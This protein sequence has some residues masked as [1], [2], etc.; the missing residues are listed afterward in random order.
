MFPTLA[1][2]MLAAPP[3]AESGEPYALLGNRLAFVTWYYVRPGGFGWYNASGQNVA[4]GGS[5]GPTGATY[6]RA[7]MPIGVR[8][9]AEKPE[10]IGPLFTDLKPW[11]TTGVHLTTVVREGDHF[12]AWGA[13]AGQ[14]PGGFCAFESTDGLHWTR[15][16]L[17]LMPVDG[18]PSN[19]IPFAEGTVFV[20]PSAP[21]EARY[22]WVQLDGMSRAD[23]DAWR[24]KHPDRWEPRAW[25]EDV[26]TAY[27]IIGATSPD[28][29]HWARLPE[30][31]VVEHSDTQIVATY[32]RRLRKYVIYTRAWWVGDR[33]EGVAPGAAWHSVGRR[34]IGRTESDT[35]DA[36]PVSQTI[37]TPPNDFPPTDLLYTNCHTELPGAPDCQLLFPAIWHLLDDT[38]SITLAGSQ[39]G[40]VW[41]YLPG[42][43]LFDTPPFGE[44]DGGCVFTHPNL[45]ELPDGS[46]VL[47]YT[48]YLFPHKYPRGQLKYNAGLLRWPK[49][50]LTAIVAD[51]QGEFAT[52][53]FVPPGASL[54]INA[55]TARG[56]RIL[57]EAAGLNGAPLPGRSFAEA[58]AI[59]GDQYRS[60][61]TWH[62]QSALPTD[63]GIML[64]I[65][66]DRARLYWLE[67][68]R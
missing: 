48:G 42:T 19:L 3:H 18:Q 2:L 10:R 66:L 22:K 21:P 29:L 52:V 41:S 46:F 6:R 8:L 14:H 56:G 54:R 34:S 40:V 51:E 7:D 17:G 38:T 24:A 50:R 68:E 58:D 27:S 37:L 36:F 13:A 1:C 61:V 31:L 45:V 32:D 30:P 16:D 4:V 25:R 28:G 67:F 35:F 9:T 15:P 20:D 43:P 59:V 47:P 5:E 55:L 39:D 23:Y 65:R 60:P 57:I 63:Q 49:G 33:A 11:E 64:R 12:R 62:G 53:G 44:W 26:G